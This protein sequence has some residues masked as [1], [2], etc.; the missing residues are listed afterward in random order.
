MPVSRRQIVRA[1]KARG[2]QVQPDALK[3]IESY[4]ERHDEVDG[5][6]LDALAEHMNDSSK[7]T[8]TNVV[9][10]AFL[11]EQ[12]SFLSAATADRPGKSSSLTNPWSNLQVVSAFR[13]ARL[14]YHTMKKNFHVEDQPWSL[15]GKAEDKVR[16]TS[17]ILP[18]S[19]LS[20]QILTEYV[21]L[22]FFFV[23]KIQIQ[24][25]VQRYAL[26]YQRVLRHELFRPSDLAHLGT[27]S[28]AVQY[29][30]TPIESL[31]GRQ[32]QQ[33]HKSILLLGL[34]QQVEE[35][36]YYLEDLTGQVPISFQ[37]AKV[38]EGFFVTEGNILLVEGAFQDGILYAQRIGH[39]L[40]EERNASM[41]VIQQQ[42][43]HPAFA[44]YEP[45]FSDAPIVLLSDIYL[46]QPRVLQQLEALLASFE[47][48]SQNRLPL[49][50][51]ILQKSTVQSRDY[52]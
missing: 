2:W 37:H 28:E 19:C 24:M 29:K 8:L 18:T 43:R 3:G 4:L 32:K 11:K 35:G 50:C 13:D 33:K 38:V 17:H 12:E 25:H 44:P 47:N 14:V 42:V 52:V 49:F 36:Q 46:D 31:L 41:S 51:F 34:L 7:R 48:Y 40:L 10:Q 26:T 16:T 20:L 21:W 27:G 6:F 45:T 9:W 39:P 22:Q 5:D 1:C 30:L 23:L 15:F